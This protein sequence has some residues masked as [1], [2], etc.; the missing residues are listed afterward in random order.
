MKPLREDVTDWSHA[1]VAGRVGSSSWQM[2][3]SSFAIF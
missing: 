1:E 2:A 3:T